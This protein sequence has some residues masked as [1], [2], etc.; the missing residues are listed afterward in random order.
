MVSNIPICYSSYLPQ[1]ENFQLTTHEDL[2]NLQGQ[3]NT[4]ISDRIAGD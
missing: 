4:E 2:S 3:L 1:T